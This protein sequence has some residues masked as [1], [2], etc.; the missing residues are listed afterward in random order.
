MRAIKAACLARHSSCAR[1]SAPGDGGGV[2]ERDDTAGF[3]TFLCGVSVAAY[4][5]AAL[6][7]FS[8]FGMATANSL[9]WH[10]GTKIEATKTNT[11]KIKKN[12]FVKTSEP[13]LQIFSLS[14]P[15]RPTDNDPKGNDPI[16]RDP[17]NEEIVH[18]LQRGSKR[19]CPM[20]GRHVG[21][22]FEFE[23]QTNFFQGM[24]HHFKAMF[25]DLTPTSKVLCTNSAEE[26]DKYPR[27]NALKSLLL[28]KCFPS[29]EAFTVACRNALGD[30]I[31]AFE[32]AGAIFVEGKC[33]VE[34]LDALEDKR[35]AKV[36]VE[37][38]YEPVAAP[39]EEK[40]DGKQLASPAEDKPNADSQVSLQYMQ[41]FCEQ[42]QPKLQTV[43]S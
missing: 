39:A 16:D 40:T 7:F 35:F 14:H 30:N 15:M 42:H 3:A 41:F 32:L 29:V 34:L 33:V 5:S 20:L 25:V 12:K 1:F 37:P 11:T 36:F 27:A 17:T 21:S 4:V 2:V 22:S 8:T 31:D 26:F 19:F 13:A 24:M 9:E 6:R 23:L 38:V 28:D 43:S 18:Y 10:K